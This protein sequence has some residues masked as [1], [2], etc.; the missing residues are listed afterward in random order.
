[1]NNFFNESRHPNFLILSSFVILCFILSIVAGYLINLNLPWLRI[2]FIPSDPKHI[3]LFIIAVIY[4]L[5][6]FKWPNIGL[7]SLIIV[8]Y[9]NVSEVGVRFHDMPSILQILVP[10]LIIVLIGLKL[11]RTDYE[12]KFQFNF[13]IFLL[14]VYSSIIFISTLYAYDTEAA[15]AKIY[16]FLK[17]FLILILVINLLNTRETLKQSIWCLVIVGAFLG[18]VSCY[19]VFTSSFGDDLGGFGRIKYAFIAG[20]VW[21]PRITGP[22]SDPN[23]YA[24]ILLVL[25][26]VVFFRL[27]D[28]QS[29]K[30]KLLSGYSLISILTTIYFTYSRAAIIVLIV[31][32]IFIV[33]IKRINLKYILIGLVALFLSALFLIPEKYTERLSSLEQLIFDEEINEISEDKEIKNIHIDSSFQQRILYMQTAW[34]MFSDHPY[35][36]VGIGNYG[37]HY[38]TYSEEVGSIVSSYEHFD[39]TRFPHNLY[40]EIGAESGLFGL[41]IFLAIIFFTFLYLLSAYINFKQVKDI[42]SAGIALSLIIGLLGYLMSSL[43]LHG[44]YIR[45]LLLLVA[46]A[47]ATER[48]SKSKIKTVA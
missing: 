4:T 41:F 38:N 14:L 17:G 42:T 45:Y 3:F 23:Y 10:F 24:Q 11:V 6:I 13:L 2:F 26:P 19:Q 39:K 40:L 27:W 32:F 37:S 25:V 29:L 33:L 7:L 47:I 31:E 18:T 21:L 20:D 46:F 12:F 30:L 43:F 35:T 44:E 48:I 16:Q 36:G 9:S 1:M 22:L 34:V 28:E 15:D 5:V 8:V